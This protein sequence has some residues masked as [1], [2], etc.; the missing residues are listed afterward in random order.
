M[1]SESAEARARPAHAGLRGSVCGAD[2]GV[3]PAVGRRDGRMASTRDQRE[4]MGERE[5]DAR[6]TWEKDQKNGPGVR[7]R[8]AGAP[9]TRGLYPH[10]TSRN[11]PPTAGGTL[12]VAANAALP[13]RGGRT[14]DAER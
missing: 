9:G 5:A 4:R 10:G 13:P 11:G 3:S 1:A 7:R 6:V 2:G 14:P 12:L 8:P